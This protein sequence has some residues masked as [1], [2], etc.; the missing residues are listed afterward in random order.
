MLKATVWGAAAIASS[1]ACAAPPEKTFDLTIARGEVAAHARVLRVEKDD[2]IRLRVTSDTPGELHLHG[3]RMEVKVR[4]GAVSEIAF[5][6]HATGRYPFEWHGGGDP[7]PRTHHG[8]P[9]A[10]LK[11]HPK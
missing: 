9:L 6:A 7:A 3:Y 2:G 10:V 11:V 8:P 1:I 5:R 4:P